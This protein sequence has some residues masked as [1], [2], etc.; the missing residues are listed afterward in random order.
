MFLVA[1]LLAQAQVPG[2]AEEE[3][4]VPDW[5]NEINPADYVL[6]DGDLPSDLHVDRKSVV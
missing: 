6:L 3:P 2:M 5:I 1:A 4:D